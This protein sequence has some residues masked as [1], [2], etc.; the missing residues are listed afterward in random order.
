MLLQ[1]FSW[2]WYSKRF[3][4]WLI[5]DEVIGDYKNCA[6]FFWLSQAYEGHLILLTFG[7]AQTE[8]GLSKKYNIWN[9]LSYVVR[10]WR[11]IVM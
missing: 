3:G 10:L 7:V 6:S 11:V 8:V 2:F 9:Y 5:F 1:I 4:N